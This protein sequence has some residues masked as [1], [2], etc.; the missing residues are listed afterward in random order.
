MSSVSDTVFTMDISATYEFYSFSFQ[1]FLSDFSE[2]SMSLVNFSHIFCTILISSSNVLRLS[3]GPTLGI[4][5]VHSMN[6]RFISSLRSP[7]SAL[8]FLQFYH[9][10]IALLSICAPLIGELGDHGVLLS[11]CFLMIL[12]VQIAIF[13][14]FSVSPSFGTVGWSVVEYE[15][16]CLYEGF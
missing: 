15:E 11:P 12:C 3:P 9:L 1:V 7:S 14:L 10:I 13:C 5:S 16:V 2:E 8:I 4:L 6:F